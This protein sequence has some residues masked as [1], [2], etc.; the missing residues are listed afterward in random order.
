MFEILI[1][2][3]LFCF[4]VSRPFDDHFNRTVNKNKYRKVLFYEEN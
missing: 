2:E 1:A 4:Q 3:I